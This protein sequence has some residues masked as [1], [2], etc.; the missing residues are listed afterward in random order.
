MLISF[1]NAPSVDNKFLEG[2]FLNPDICRVSIN[3]VGEILRDGKIN[4]IWDC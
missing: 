2:L 1:Q 4:Q 3:N